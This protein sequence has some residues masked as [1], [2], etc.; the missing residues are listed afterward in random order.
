MKT[1]QYL[2]RELKK[3][4][5]TREEIALMLVKEGA[6]DETEINLWEDYLIELILCVV[7]CCCV[8]LFI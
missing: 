6:I 5:Q 2:V 1:I 8:A 7:M 4:S 3:P